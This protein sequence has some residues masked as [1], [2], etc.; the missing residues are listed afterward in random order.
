MFAVRVNAAGG[1]DALKYEQVADPT[2]GPGQ[3]L[4]RVE[5]AGVNFIDVYQRSGLY[6]VQY[7]F[8]PG[9]EGAGTVLAVAPGV[10]TVS[11]GDIVAWAG[12]PGS[13]AQLCVVQ[14]DRLVQLPAGVTTRQAAAA[15][16]QGITAHYLT[17][18]TYPLRAGETCLV[19]AAAGGVGQLLCQMAR[20]RG[21]RVIGTVGSQAKIAT[22]KEAG[23]DDVIV[24]T[25]E[26]F[27][28]ETRR[29]TGGKG[30]QVVYDSVGRTTFD[31][32]L[33]CLA[34]RGVMVLYGQSSGPVPPFDPQ[35][36]NQRGSLFLTRPSIGHH[37]ASRTE[38]L[39]R[40]GDVLGWV[41]ERR[42]R[43]RVDLELPLAQ[44]AEAHR[45]LEARATTGKVLLLPEAA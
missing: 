45:R 42:L 30:V 6:R 11:A 26:D 39:A 31:A 12:P 29:L 2:P 16:L 21:A 34:P 40:A 13:Y 43:L 20:M 37:T 8:V 22:A 24:Y 23:A 15:M 28:A 44:A 5:A 38:L 18:S 33:R 35:I 32:S 7:P 17:T 9:Q 25:D 1:A 3:A 10:T 27:E 14:A 4:V 36:L 41:A 19:H